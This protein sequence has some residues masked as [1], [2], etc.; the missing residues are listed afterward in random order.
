MP[1][2]DLYRSLHGSIVC[3]PRMSKAG[4]ARRDIQDASS[5]GYQG[6]ECLGQREYAFEMK[7]HGFIEQ[8]FRCI[9]ERC[10]NGAPGIADEKVECVVLSVPD[11]LREQ[12]FGK[13]GGLLNAIDILLQCNGLA[14]QLTDFVHDLHGRRPVMQIWGDGPQHDFRPAP[15]PVSI[16]YANRRRLSRRARVFMDWMVQ[17]MKGRLEDVRS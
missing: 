4:Q 15:M 1:A 9:G 6:N 17:L 13:F 3:I 7:V 12:C 2:E 11:Q 16:L 14:S 8:L 5:V 10:V